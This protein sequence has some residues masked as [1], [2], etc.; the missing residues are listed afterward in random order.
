MLAR[1]VSV[2]YEIRKTLL[3]IMSQRPYHHVK[4]G[5]ECRTEGDKVSE[6][7]GPSSE[8]WRIIHGLQQQQL[9]QLSTFT[10]TDPH[11]DTGSACIRLICRL[12]LSPS[13]PAAKRL[14]LMVVTVRIGISELVLPHPERSGDVTEEPLRG[15]V[16]AR[17]RVRSSL[18]APQPVLWDSEPGNAL[19]PS[20][21]SSKR[22][23]EMKS[24]KT[25]GVKKCKPIPV[26]GRG[27]L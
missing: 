23:E 10:L 13:R 4:M 15:G 8:L 20:A 1:I 22:R 3:Q 26:T 5:T 12:C 19:L 7:W 6:T 24:R 2:P 18:K 11:T 17:V 27:G 9:R 25:L 14:I 21:N 16:R